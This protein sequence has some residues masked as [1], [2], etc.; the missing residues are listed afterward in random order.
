MLL[1]YWHPTSL[2]RVALRQNT[3]AVH[4]L[5]VYWHPTSLTRVALTQNTL[6]VY[7]LLV[8]WHPTSLTRV[9]LRQSTLAANLAFVCRNP[10]SSANTALGQ[11]H[12]GNPLGMCI[13]A[14]S[15]TSQGISQ[16]STVTKHPGNHWNLYTVTLYHQ[17][18]TEAWHPWKLSRHLHKGNLNNHPGQHPG[19]QPVQ[20]SIC[21][22]FHTGTLYCSYSDKASVDAYLQFGRGKTT[23]GI[24]Q[25][26]IWPG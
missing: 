7:M 24:W 1:V 12:L 8:Y 10:I 17:A 19:N 5:L 20:A 3:L 22:I 2:T 15:I 16:G 11:K 6:A 4:M 13:H 26:I 23:T 18:S 9:A 21:K 14:P 25:S